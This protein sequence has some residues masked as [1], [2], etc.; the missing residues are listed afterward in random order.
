MQ[1]PPVLSGKQRESWKGL[2]IEREKVIVKR[3]N[4]SGELPEGQ[5]ERKKALV[6]RCLK[7]WLRL[8]SKERVDCLFGLVGR[9]SDKSV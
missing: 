4:V 6:L 8:I 1:L 7:S 3:E 5:K 9:L 2:K